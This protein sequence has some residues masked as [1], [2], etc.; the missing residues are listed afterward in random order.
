MN[1]KMLSIKDNQLKL[2]CNYIHKCVQQDEPTAAAAINKIR[3][4]Q[5]PPKFNLP[6]PPNP[7]SFLHSSS[8]ISSTSNE[9]F[10]VHYLNVNNNS[11]DNNHQIDKCTYF[12]IHQFKSSKTNNVSTG[13]MSFTNFHPNSSLPK[14]VINN[15]NNNKLTSTS[16]VSKSTINNYIKYNAKDS[17]N[18]NNQNQFYNHL[19]TNKIL[20]TKDNDQSFDS[21]SYFQHNFYIYSAITLLTITVIIL[22]FYFLF[23]R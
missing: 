1:D 14:L 20:N 10:L 19:T 17:N 2:S 21:N 9:K 23:A 15:N 4:V 13:S 6:Q 5:P 12:K 16:I 11:S 18:N 8:S 7:I 3:I 22:A